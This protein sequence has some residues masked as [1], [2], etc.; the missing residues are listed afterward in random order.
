MDENSLE[1]LEFHRV[2]EIVA[3]FT[4]FSASRELVMALRPLSDRDQISLLLKQSGEAR[5]LLSLKPDFSIGGVLDVRGHAKMAAQGKILEPQKLIEIQQA[6]CA[7]R[8]L[9]LGID[10]LSSRLPLLWNMAEGIVELRYIETNVGNCVSPAGEI[11]ESASPKL[12][13]IRHRLTTARK[14]LIEHL[15]SI[16]R[17]PR[18]RRIIGEPIV[19]EREGRYVVPVKIE[20]RKEIKGIVHDVSNTGATAFVEPWATVE[21][22]NTL[23]Q[24]ITEEQHEVERILTDL[25][26]E[27]G[28]HEAEICDNIA[29][30]AD[31]DVALAKARYADYAKASEPLLNGRGDE[32]GTTADASAGMLKLIEARHPLLIGKAVPLSVEIGRDFF[33]LVITGPNTGGKTVALKTIGL[34]ALMAQAGLPIPASEKSS[35]PVF[36]AVFADIGDEQSIEQTLSSFSWHMSNILRITK[37]VTQRSLVLLDELGASTDPVEGS[38]LGRSILLYFLSRGAFVVATTHYSDLKVFAHSTSGLQNASLEFDPATLVPTY[39]LTVGLPGGS[40]ALATASRLGL[41]SDIVDRA[42]EML[43]EGTRHM[44]NVLADLM[45]EKHRIE[46]LRADLQEEKDEAERLNRDLS[47]ELQRLT[48]DERRVIEETRDRVV[49]EAAQLHRDIR[50][51]ASELRKKKSKEQM[52]QAKKTLAS[53]QQRLHGDV[54]QATITPMNQEDAGSGSLRAGDRVRLREANV[55]AKVLSLSERTMQIEVQVGQT[56]LW[57]GFDGVEKVTQSSPAE[58]PRAVTLKR[59]YGT[60]R[61]EP[62]LDLRGKRAEEIEWT[63]DSYLNSAWLAALSE[64]RIIHGFGTGTVRS[65]VRDFLST[66]SLVSSFRAGG[67]SEGGDGVTVVQLQQH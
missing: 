41:P 26:I 67:K 10:G 24:L 48:S 14:E 65:I 34:L 32:A 43:P 35:I 23:R 49:Q 63:V 42:K 27:V 39:H 52:E 58:P 47:N 37:N 56:R 4:S 29:L 22:G 38:A 45:S 28:A 11:L 16:I 18:G 6:L 30:A 64:A 33:G 15:E 1:M 66:H 61:V 13:T 25:S 50:H 55:E 59:G 19:T 2:R 9:R 40:N 7:I 62:Q 3:G 54:W 57:L 53:V 5:R 20:R 44:E 12:A 46:A 17:S 21:Q 51:C 36:D 60:N 31:I 8:R